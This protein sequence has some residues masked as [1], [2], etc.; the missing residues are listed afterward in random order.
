MSERGFFPASNDIKTLDGNIFSGFPWLTTH[1]E[2][3]GYQKPC[4]LAGHL[5]RANYVTSG[6][7]R[8]DLCDVASLSFLCETRRFITAR[9]AYLAYFLTHSVL[10]AAP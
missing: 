10:K 6:I 1:L 8:V 9:G 4:H 2:V 7:I 5:W 3:E